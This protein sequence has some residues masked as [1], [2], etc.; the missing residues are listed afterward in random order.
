MTYILE[1]CTF[2]AGGF[3]LLA[4]AF[5]TVLRVT[6]QGKYLIY[7][8]AALGLALAVVLTEWFWV[9]DNERIEQVVFDLRRA[10]LA[11][12]VEGVLA[13]LAPDVQYLQKGTALSPEATQ[14][15]IRMNLSH[16]HFD[17]IHIT[18]LQTSFGEQSRRGKAEFRVLAKGTL[19]NALGTGAAG[20]AHSSWSL[21]FQET[22]P[23]VW[24]VN[25]ITPLVI[26][27]EALALAGTSVVPGSPSLGFH[28]RVRMR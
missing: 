1:D 25:R 16:S 15:L 13:Q 18:D 2:L 26:P 3:V 7:A 4:A 9:T 19:N 21:G 14:S 28:G 17:F 6:Q 10:V 24:K 23:G 27:H 12:D 20:T 8:G 5:L 11:S 22:K